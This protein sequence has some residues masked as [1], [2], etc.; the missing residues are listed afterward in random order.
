MAQLST[1]ADGLVLTIEQAAERAAERVAAVAGIETVALAAA[2]GRVLAQDVVAPLDLPPFAN[3]AVDGYAVRFADLAASG[4]TRLPVSG[5]VPAGTDAAGVT[6]AG[7][8]VRVFTGAPMPPDA[9]TVFMQEDVKLEAGT[10]LLPAGLNRGANAR[11]AGEDLPRGQTALAAGR[12]LRP[13]DLALL[14][15]L[16]VTEVAVRRRVRVAIFSTGDELSEP[17]VSLS[18]AGIYDAN[19]SLLRALVARAG[20]EIVDLGILGDEPESLAERLREAAADCDL[21]L[22]SGGVSAG[23]EDHVKAAV[24]RAGEL[25]FWRVAIKPG[26][27]VA[28]GLV[29]GTPFI[30]LPGNPVAVFVTFAFVARTVIA[31][32]A[33]TKPAPLLGLPVRLGFPYRK[34]AGRREYVRVSLVPGLD[35]VAVARKHP[36]DGAGALISLTESDGLVELADELTVVAEGTIAPFLAYEMLTG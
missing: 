26:R 13:Q 16:G 3:S 30:G 2:D 8:A 21:I 23:E 1:H 6:T 36:R 5:R 20:A 25:A 22:T 17:G 27:P 29:A 35:G 28:M 24:E 33:G 34:K 9:D 19:R 15:A 11:A 18:P 7:M 10:V 32:R 31:L 4:E 14:A 12:C